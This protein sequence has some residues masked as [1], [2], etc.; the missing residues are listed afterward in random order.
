MSMTSKR[1]TLLTQHGKES[2][3]GPVFDANTDYRLELVSGFDTD[4]LGTFGRD[5]P[6]LGSQLE[7]ARRK[8][9]LGMELG[10]SPVG[11]ASE[12]AFVMDPFAGLIPWNIEV[13]VLTDDEAQLEVVGIAQ[14][15]AQNF[16]R[17][18]ADLNSLA[19]FAD[20]ANFPS[21]HLMLRPNNAD[22]PR[23]CKGLADWRSLSD[24]FA[25]AQAQSSNGLIF[26]ES[27]LR[28]FCNPTRQKMI[29]RAAENLADKLASSCPGCRSAGFWVTEHVTG[30]KCRLCLGATRVP[31]ADVWSCTT[32]TYR[33]ERVRS[34]GAF[35]E[36]SKCDNCNP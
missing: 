30:L 3:L 2:I 11:I 33:E 4:L 17:S 19:V 35:A 26:V 36:P 21:H 1:M 9:R 16:Q 29:R 10:R 25:R 15:A 32:C 28:A 8:C 27:D 7:A 12:G 20:E 24:A 22:D 5:V 14:G 6:R 31:I 18:V 23:L 13:V 34:D